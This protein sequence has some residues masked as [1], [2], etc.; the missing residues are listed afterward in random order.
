MACGA[1]LPH[2]VC[3]L[4]TAIPHFECAQGVSRDKNNEEWGKIG[5]PGVDLIRKL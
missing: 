3:P 5:L 1:A 4:A 2:R